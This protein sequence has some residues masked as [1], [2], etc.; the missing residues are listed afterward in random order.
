MTVSPAPGVLVDHYTPPQPHRDRADQGRT[1]LPRR[2]EQAERQRTG[3]RVG[4]PGS[5]QDGQ[6]NRRGPARPGAVDPRLTGGKAPHISFLERRG[7]QGGTPCKA[8][9]PAPPSG[10]GSARTMA[11]RRRG[12]D[13][14][15]S[16]PLAAKPQDG[17]EWRQSSSPAPGRTGWRFSPAGRKYYPVLDGHQ[18][19]AAGR[20]TGSR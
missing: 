16:F 12:A 15:I 8:P 1:G 6:E 10:G 3:G 2:P 17:A 20:R 7:V 4:Q 11:R 19:R 13:V 18:A 9:H 5:P 14:H